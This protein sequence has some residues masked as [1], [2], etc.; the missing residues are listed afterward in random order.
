MDLKVHRMSWTSI[1][2]P[3][4]KHYL[5]KPRDIVH[6]QDMEHFAVEE[7]ID[8]QEAEEISITTLT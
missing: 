7:V 3:L 2:R 4:R 1:T 8:P 6:H 5:W